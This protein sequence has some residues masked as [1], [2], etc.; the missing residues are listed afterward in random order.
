MFSLLTHST[1]SI[2]CVQ[3]LMFGH[4]LLVKFFVLFHSSS[5][6]EA[7]TGEIGGG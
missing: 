4:Y 1:V 5:F 3:F 2:M 7:A 6:S